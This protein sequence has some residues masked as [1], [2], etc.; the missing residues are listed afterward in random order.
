MVFLMRCIPTSHT[1]YM[2]TSLDTQAQMV[3]ALEPLVIM[4]FTWMQKSMRLTDF[5]TVRGKMSKMLSAITSP[6][7]SNATTS[8][9]KKLSTLRHWIPLT[10]LSKFVDS[11]LKP[12]RCK[13]RSCE[14]ARFS[15]TACLLRHER[16]AHAMHGHGQKPFLCSFTGCERGQQGHGFPRHWNLRDHM[17]RVHDAEPPASYHKPSKVSRK[18]KGDAQDKA[19]SKRSPTS[20]TTHPPQF[21]CLSEEEQFRYRRGQLEEQLSQLKDVDPRDLTTKEKLRCVED[22]VKKMNSLVHAVA[23]VP[24]RSSHISG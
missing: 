22:T 24:R 6:K 2:I 19:T 3:T 7:S 12:Y 21:V 15:S 4:Y 10:K 17:R 23:K 5:T 9:I 20:T 14:N 11:H 13:V 16:E 18:R 8:M 1:R